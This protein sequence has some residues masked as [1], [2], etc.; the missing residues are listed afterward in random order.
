MKNAIEYGAKDVRMQVSHV[1]DCDLVLQIRLPIDKKRDRL[2][3]VCVPLEQVPGLET[4][5]QSVLTGSKHSK[6][7]NDDPGAMV[8]A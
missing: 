3:W 6:A 5:L 1:T 8:A 4:E 7:A 2:E